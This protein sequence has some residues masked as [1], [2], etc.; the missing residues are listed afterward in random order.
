MKE[1]QDEIQK[2]TDEVSNYREKLDRIQSKLLSG[3]VN[4]RGRNSVNMQ[5]YDRYDHCNAD[6][7]SGFSMSIMFPQYK[8]LE[9]SHMIFSLENQRSLCYKINGMIEKPLAI[10]SDWIMSTIGLITPR[11]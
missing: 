10:T 5:E 7:V 11:Q 4:A 2:L 3:D 1:Y 9:P 8:F 6:I